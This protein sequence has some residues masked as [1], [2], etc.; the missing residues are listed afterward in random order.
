MG[1]LGRGVTRST[2][3]SEGMGFELGSQERQALLA[4]GRRWKAATLGR[5]S[6]SGEHRQVRGATGGVKGQ[7][8]WSQGCRRQ[9][10]TSKSPGSSLRAFRP[11]SWEQFKI[12]SLKTWRLDSLLECWIGKPR[13]NEATFWWQGAWCGCFFLLLPLLFLLFPLQN[14]KNASFCNKFVNNG[15]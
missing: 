13:N 7:G 6:K 14:S 1:L 11:L 10:V 9:V 8:P 2:R 5:V 15:T 12:R 3:L 4:L